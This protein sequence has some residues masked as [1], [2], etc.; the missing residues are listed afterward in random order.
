MLMLIPLIIY[1]AMNMTIFSGVF[2]SLMTRS[3][4]NSQDIHPDLALDTKKQNH[5][6]LYAMVLR[7]VGDIVGGNLVG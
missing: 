6:A 5:A 4:A 3:M 7:G 2:I 1:S